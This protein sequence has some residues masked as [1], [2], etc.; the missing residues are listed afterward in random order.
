MDGWRA[1]RWLRPAPPACV[2]VLHFDGCAPRQGHFLLPTQRHLISTNCARPLPVV[3]DV[4]IFADNP[5]LAL[6]DVRTH[7]QIQTNR[8]KTLLVT[9]N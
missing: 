8:H 3:S 6:S 2:L 9:C 7:R 1:D 4:S 5:L